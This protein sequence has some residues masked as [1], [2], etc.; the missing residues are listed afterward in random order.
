MEYH[1]EFFR[2]NQPNLLSLIKRTSKNK[3]K[4]VAAV[5]CQKSMIHDEEEELE[6]SEKDD[7]AQKP[8]YFPA[9]KITSS[10]ESAGQGEEER[11]AV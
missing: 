7:E 1:H 5:A 6:V 8:A 3:G 10:S 2:K 9:A 11:A 4:A